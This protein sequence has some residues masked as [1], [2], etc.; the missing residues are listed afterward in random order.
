MDEVSFALEKQKRV[1]PVLYRE[2][3]V[4]LRLRLKVFKHVDFR[5]D[6]DRGFNLLQLQPWV[7][8]NRRI[9]ALLRLP[10]CVK[11]PRKSITTLPAPPSLTERVN[12]FVKTGPFSAELKVFEQHR[13]EWIAFAPR[14][15]CC[16]PRRRHRGRILQHL[17]GRLQG[18]SAE[19][20][21]PSSVSCKAGMD[22]RASVFRLIE[23]PAL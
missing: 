12:A 1:I 10:R 18:R 15:V 21:C 11:G 16:D 6:Y 2:C 20:W 19:V 5:T 13:E 22:D 17:R 8:S 7:W 23:W 4:P 3:E 9:D 14:R